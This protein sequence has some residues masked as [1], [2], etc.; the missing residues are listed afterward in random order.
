MPEG[1][2]VKTIVD[3]LNQILCGSSIE[4][5]SGI[6]KDLD[7][8][9][10]NSF[11]PLSVKKV[12]CKGKQ[13]YIELDNDWYI[14]N[15]L[16]MSGYWSIQPDKY[17]RLTFEYK[18]E[19]KESK[20]YFNDVRKFAKTYFLTKKEALTILDD[21]GED[22]LNDNIKEEKF[23]SNLKKC[24]KK[25]L[26]KCLMDQRSICSSI[27]NYLLSEILHRANI[28]PESK[29]SEVDGKKLYNSC[30]E[31]ITESYDAKGVSK[32]DYKDVDGEKGSYYNC[33]RVYEK[34]K[35]EK[36]RKVVKI[37]GKHSRSI[38]YVPEAF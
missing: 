30:K 21:I 4:K 38:Y 37:K 8:E 18:K 22:F 17:T 25:Y 6:S 5:V 29:C 24:G 10:I 2:E 9:K 33:L 12:G 16:M 31:V 20:I 26:V 34:T 11:L 19:G 15:H 28:H 27:G 7:I 36:G 3:S 1:P 14:L 35:D 13:I 23:I 32:K